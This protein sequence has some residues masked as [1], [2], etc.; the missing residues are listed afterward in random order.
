[1]LIGHSQGSFTLTSLI[2]AEIDS[3]PALRRKLVS[4][5]IIGGQVTVPTGKDVGGGAETWL[6]R[7]DA[8]PDSDIVAW[9]WRAARPKLGTAHR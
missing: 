1:M 6:Q 2:A 5:L 4:A 7:Q 9:L 3:K 8:D